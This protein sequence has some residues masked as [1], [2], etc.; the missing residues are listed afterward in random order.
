MQAGDRL[1]LVGKS[2]VQRVLKRAK[3][4]EIH[5]RGLRRW[6]SPGPPI[7]ANGFTGSHSLIRDWFEPRDDGFPLLN[8][9]D[10]STTAPGLFF[11]GP[12]VRHG[13]HVFC[14]IYKFR[15][16]FAVVAK[17]IADRLGLPAE[18]LE[19]YR[20]WVMYLD[21]LSCCGEACVC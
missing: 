4:Y 17:A 20:Q 8:E 19:T 21:D 5:A 9:A 7:L 13:Q 1:K 15:Q 16:R 2:T 6:Y 18:Q 3:H 14:F 12:M 10:E 11:A